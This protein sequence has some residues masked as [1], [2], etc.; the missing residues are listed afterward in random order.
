[1]NSREVTI[2]GKVYTAEDYPGEK[3]IELTQPTGRHRVV[4]SGE[5]VMSMTVSGAAPINLVD[6]VIING[7]RFV[8]ENVT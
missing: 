6:V 8:P 2:G 7:R 4:T 1:M 5:Y 3:T